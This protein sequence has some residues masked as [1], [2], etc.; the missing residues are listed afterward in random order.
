MG[1]AEPIC[2]LVKLADVV[3]LSVI[4]NNAVQVC[5][6]WMSLSYPLSIQPTCSPLVWDCS[7]G[8]QEFVYVCIEGHIVLRMGWLKVRPNVHDLY[9]WNYL[10]FSFLL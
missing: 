7:I 10:Y 5:P 8:K 1:E 9:H 6:K 2:G 3:V 4:V